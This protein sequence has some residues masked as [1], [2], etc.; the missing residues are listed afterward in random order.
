MFYQKKKYN[1]KFKLIPLFIFFLLVG[2]GVFGSGHNV[3]AATY[4]MNPSGT[5]DCSNLHECFAV[6]QGG[7]TLVIRDG[8]YENSSDNSIQP[9][10]R[11]P[12][13]NSSKY[14]KII[15]EHPGKVFFRKR[16]DQNGMFRLSGNG[17]VYYWFEGIIWKQSIGIYGTNFI[18][19]FRC[20]VDNEDNVMGTA[21]SIGSSENILLEECYAWG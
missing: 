14:T 11:H 2:I 1:Q 16:Y 9:W 10:N 3:M 12:I 21:F 4:Y 18:K 19:M 8:V 17:D 13:G 5:E 15:A 20:A 7:D 6:M